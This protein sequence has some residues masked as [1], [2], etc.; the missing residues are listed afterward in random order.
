[1]SANRFL[2]R[3]FVQGKEK[4]EQENGE[5]YVT[6]R[7]IICT[8]PNCVP[9]ILL[10]LERMRWAGYTR[11]GQMRNVYSISVTKAEM[12]KAVGALGVDGPRIFESKLNKKG[13]G[14]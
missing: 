8:Q 9:M 3:V 5:N 4:M 1:M 6:R 13:V 11:L 12:K 7:Y 2:M 10:V 14:V